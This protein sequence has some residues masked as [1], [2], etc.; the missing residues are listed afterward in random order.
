MKSSSYVTFG[1]STVKLAASGMARR[2]QAGGRPQSAAA[3]GA[4]TRRLG[5]AHRALRVER[6]CALAPWPAAAA[7]PRR[8]TA[9]GPARPRCSRAWAL[10]SG[11]PAL[12]TGHHS[13][14]SS[15]AHLDG[16]PATAWQRPGGQLQERSP[17]PRPPRQRARCAGHAAPLSA[18][19]HRAARRRARA[20]GRAARGCARCTG[21]ISAGRWSMLLSQAA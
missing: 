2:K 4:K 12:P 21:A 3:A 18:A 10:V 13:L 20:G 15:V 16:I 8:R 6:R 19:G 9:V 14:P 11:G 7:W 1:L 5:K 17:G